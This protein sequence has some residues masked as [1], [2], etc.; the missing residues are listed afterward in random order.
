MLPSNFAVKDDY[1]S[2]ER[3]PSPQMPLPS[4]PKSRYFGVGWAFYNTLTVVALADVG[5]YGQAPPNSPLP[6]DHRLELQRAAPLVNSE[7]YRGGGV[8]NGDCSIVQVI[9]VPVVTAFC[10]IIANG[11]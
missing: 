5:P 9:R 7:C 8:V 3:T 10:Q 1:D 6:S 4:C 2:D 11:E